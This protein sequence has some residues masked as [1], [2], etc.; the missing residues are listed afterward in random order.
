M[1]INAPSQPRNPSRRMASS[2]NE[3]SRMETLSSA[4][5]SMA[6]RE[7][8][9]RLRNRT[10]YFLSATRARTIGMP[11]APVP[12]MTKILEVVREDIGVCFLFCEHHRRSMMVSSGHRCPCRVLA[13]GL[14]RSPGGGGV[15]LNRH[16]GCAADGLDEIV[17]PGEHITALIVARDVAQVLREE[18]RRSL[19]AQRGGK[20]FGVDGFIADRN[21]QRLR[22]FLRDL[23][24]VQFLG[25]AERD[26]V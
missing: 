24:V 11:W 10:E 25:I 5:R 6:R 2:A 22:D 20:R 15:L 26:E 19:S 23:V 13:L 17:C 14:K 12:P 9:S 7:P 16:R 18:C 1:L 21:A 8:E 4:R 3:P